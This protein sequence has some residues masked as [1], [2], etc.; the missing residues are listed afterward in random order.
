MF[1]K[2]KRRDNKRGKKER[3]NIKNVKTVYKLPKTYP[4]TSTASSF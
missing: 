4:S 2:N 3:K 1:I